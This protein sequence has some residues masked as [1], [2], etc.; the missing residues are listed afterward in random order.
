VQANRLDVALENRLQSLQS[1]YVMTYERA[2]E[3][4]T[5]VS[6]TE[7][8]KEDVN[9]IKDRIKR[10][11]TVN[12]GAIDEYSRLKERYEFLTEQQAD[13]IE[14]KTTLYDVIQEMDQE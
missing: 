10:L 13:L 12:L 2:C 1:E 7:K 3:L 8:A 11:G 6:D 4:Y 9:K 5:P 14:A